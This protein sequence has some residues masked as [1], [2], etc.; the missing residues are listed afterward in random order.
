MAQHL[1][2]RS[3]ISSMVINILI[4]SIQTIHISYLNFT[5]VYA[6]TLIKQNIYMSLLNHSLT[7]KNINPSELHWSRSS[8]KDWDPKWVRSCSHTSAVKFISKY[9]TLYG[10]SFFKISRKK[11]RVDV[12]RILTSIR[13]WICL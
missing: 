3:Q 11:R 8:R 5:D 6:Y 12:A 2:T 7:T 10:V 4:N 9:H 1:N 13:I